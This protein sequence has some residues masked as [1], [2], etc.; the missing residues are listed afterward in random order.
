MGALGSAAEAHERRR[1]RLGQDPQQPVPPP[2][3][4]GEP[5]SSRAPPRDSRGSTGV[6]SPCRSRSTCHRDVRSR[7]LL[8]VRGRISG[9]P[10][11]RTSWTSPSCRPGARAGLPPRGQECRQRAECDDGQGAVV[12]G[13]DSDGTPNGREPAGLAGRAAVWGLRPR[14][15]A[16]GPHPGGSGTA[17][18]SMS[19]CDAP[20]ATP[21]TLPIHSTGVDTLPDVAP[22][23][24][25]RRGT[26]AP[27]RPR[28]TWD[29]RLH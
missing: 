21:W 29:R 2:R 26:G 12:D 9:R 3:E 4:S 8:P 20:E 28:A 25:R 1:D 17:P 5:T 19:T 18:E 23:G 15:R 6:A 10:T 13:S 22:S 24:C 7:C 14:S 27:T 16:H 11:G